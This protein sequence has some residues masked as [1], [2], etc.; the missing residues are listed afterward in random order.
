MS[1]NTWTR[2]LTISS[3]TPCIRIRMIMEIY[4]KSGFKPLFFFAQIHSRISVWNDKNILKTL[5]YIMHKN[6]KFTRPFFVYFIYWQKISIVKMY[7]DA[8]NILLKLP[9]DI[10]G[11]WWKCTKKFEK[12]CAKCLL[13]KFG[14]DNFSSACL[15]L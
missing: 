8:A 7:K 14:V 13:T 1:W 6:F 5:F 4:R 9:I 2:T 15:R 10:C 12:I 3:I 11:Q